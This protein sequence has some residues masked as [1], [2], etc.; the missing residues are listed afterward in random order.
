[1]RFSGWEKIKWA[2]RSNWKWGAA[3]GEEGQVERCTEHMDLECTYDKSPNDPLEQSLLNVITRV[4]VQEQELGY[5]YIEVILLLLTLQP[6]WVNM[7]DGRR[8]E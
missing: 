7:Q 2:W 1:M 3:G 4:L 8:V 6:G 5:Y